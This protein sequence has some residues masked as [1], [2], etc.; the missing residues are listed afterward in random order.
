MPPSLWDAQHSVDVLVAL[1]ATYLLA[2][3]LGW[4]RKATGVTSIGLRTVPLVAVGTCAYLLIARFL[5]E[6]GVFDADGQA[7]ALRAMMTGIGF[8]GG[9]AILKDVK[10][11]PGVSGIAT[12][13]VVWTAGAIGASVAHAY[14]TLAVALTLTNLFVMAVTGWLA[15]HVVRVDKPG[16]EPPP[17]E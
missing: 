6:K 2:A 16:D 11:V 9:G 7:R 13:T 3:P 17:D 14:Y 4:E 12:A 15:R 10:G 8:I 5:F 1:G